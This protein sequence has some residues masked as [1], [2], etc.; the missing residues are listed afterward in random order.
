MDTI[1]YREIDPEGF[2]TLAVIAEAGRFNQWMYNTIAPFC[3]GKILEIGSGIGNISNFFIKE[4]RNIVLSDIRSNYCDYL[5]RKFGLTNE[6][7]VRNLNLTDPQIEERF[8]ELLGTFDTV[9]ALNV[10]EHIEEDQLAIA[11]CVKFLKPGGKLIILVPAFNLLYNT[12]DKELGHYRRYTKSVLSKIFASSGLSISAAKYFNAMGMVGWFISGR[13]QRN[14]TIPSGQM[15]LYNALVPVFRIADK[16]VF[17]QVG[18][19]VIVVGE[20]PH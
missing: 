1:E 12:F 15:K 6:T 19:S 5:E 10:V 11:N 18:L 20:K 9:F 7:L 14:K 3:Q 2:Q 4:N 8:G 13:F 16:V 17:N